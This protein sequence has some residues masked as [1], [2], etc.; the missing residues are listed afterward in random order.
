MQKNIA[1]HQLISILRK[2]N[3]VVHLTTSIF[4]RCCGAL[5]TSIFFF[6]SPML[7]FVFFYILFVFLILPKTANLETDQPKQFARSNFYI[8]IQ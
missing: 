3:I 2:I 7:F 4:N 8:T 6:R 5:T 1:V